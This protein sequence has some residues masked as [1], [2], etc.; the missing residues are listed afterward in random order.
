MLF[1]QSKLNYDYCDYKFEYLFILD[2]TMM[3]I[4]ITM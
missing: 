1:P 2:I 3:F 4:D